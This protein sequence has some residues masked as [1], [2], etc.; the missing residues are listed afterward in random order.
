MIP[1]ADASREFGLSLS[2]IHR[3]IRAG[4]L[5]AHKRA[6]GLVRTFVDRTELRKLLEPKPARRKTR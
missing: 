5:T 2:T 3:H 1:L 6:G 4:R